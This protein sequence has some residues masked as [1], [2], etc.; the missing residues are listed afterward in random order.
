MID[1][2]HNHLKDDVD[3]LLT[4]LSHAAAHGAGTPGRKNALFSAGL[5]LMRLEKEIARMRDVILE[6]EDDDEAANRLDRNPRTK[7]HLTEV[8]ANLDQAVN[9]DLNGL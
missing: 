3:G 2:S 5:R 4:H 1:F 7:A 8:A 9:L 6:L